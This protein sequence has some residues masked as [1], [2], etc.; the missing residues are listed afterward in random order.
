MALGERLRGDGARVYCLVSDGELQE[1]QVW[2]AAM[3]ASH[4]GLGNLTVLI[5]NNHIQADGA[6]A[7][8]MGVEPVVNASAL[9]GSIPSGWTP[10]TMFS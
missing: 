8:V 7:E 1:G 4:F 9:S 3:S 5:D 2:E 10:T 6:T